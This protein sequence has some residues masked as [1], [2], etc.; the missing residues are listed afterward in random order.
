MGYRSQQGAAQLFGLPVQPRR[1]Q[2][3]GQPRPC[4]GLG[5][6]LAERSEQAPALAAE[7]LALTGADT[8]QPQGPVIHRQRP[9]P[10]S[11]K[12]Q[13]PGAQPRRLVMLPGPVGRRALGLGELRR[14]TGL[15]F[16]ST[17][18]VAV[19]QADTQLVAT[20]QMLGRGAD[21][22]LPVSGGSQLARQVQELAGFLLGIAQGLQL[23]ALA[24]RQIAGQRGHEQEEQQGQHILFPLDGQGEVRR[25]EQEVITE[26]GQRRASQ[27]RPQAAAHRHQQHRGEEHQ[28]D[29]RQRQDTGHPPGQGAGQEGGQDC[30]DVVEPDQRMLD[31]QARLMGLGLAVQ[32]IDLQAIG[33]AQQARRQAATEPAPAPAAPGL[34][35]QQQ[36]GA[37][38]RGVLDQ[39]LGHLAG[40]QQ[41]HFPAQALGQLLSGL[42]AQACLLVAQPAVIHMHQAPGQVATLS[43]TA[44]VTY[45]PLGL[46]IAVDTHQQ[47]PAHRRCRLPQ[48]AIALGQVVVHL[49]GGGLHRQFA[50][51]GEVGLGEKCIDGRPRLLRHVDLA[52]PQTLQQLSGRQVHQQQLIGLLQHPVRQGF[53]HLDPGNAAHLVI[54]AFQVLDID[55]GEDVDPGRQQLLN[56]LPALGV[57]AA[58]GIAVGQFVHQYQLGLGLEQAVEVHFLQ[59]YATVF[60]T[61]QGLLG[62][63]AQQGFGLGAAVGL[64]HP[65]KHLDPLAQLAMGRLEHG[66]GLANPGGGAQEHLEPAAAVP[67]QLG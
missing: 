39:G 29:V 59:Q 51:G 44:G 50:Q 19:D 61:H 45:Q 31:P 21:H 67:W 37:T 2:V 36:A 40:T 35:H 46:G 64:H 6:W 47:P 30:Q 9:P 66:V 22:R 65:G 43:H 16:P 28:G 17:L 38:L 5:Q 8:E 63:P 54:E 53:A 49:G 18:P 14:T 3:L 12:G 32:D 58:R 25:N 13:G 11:T 15:D 7:L 27:G 55:R 48:L 57:P 42:Q 1:F 26:K 62:Q 34:P 10:P 60:R 20:I 24:G 41:D 33:I 4:Q 23:P 52:V 56:V